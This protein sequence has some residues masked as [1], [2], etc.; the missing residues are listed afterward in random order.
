[1]GVLVE[2]GVGHGMLQQEATCDAGCIKV[3][4]GG[5]CVGNP[6]MGI[7]NPLPRICGGGGA[8]DLGGLW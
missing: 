1:M 5:N 7:K 3:P 8:S 4:R 2:P 6:G